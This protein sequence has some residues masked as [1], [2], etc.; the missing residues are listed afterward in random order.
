MKILISGGGLAGLT[1]A[2]WLDKY[3]FTPVVIEQSNGLRRDGYGIDFFGSGY[4]VAERMGLIE[5]LQARPIKAEYV[6]YVNED[7]N[8]IAKLDIALMR[9]IMDGRYLPLMHRT[10]EETLYQAIADKVEVRFGCSLTAITQTPDT[11]TATFDD[12][13]REAFDLLI[14]ADGIHSRTRSL[15][16]GPESEFAHYLGY[17]V[18]CYSLPDH[19]HIGR[20]WQNYTEPGRQVGAYCSDRAGELITLFMWEAP[21]EG[22]VPRAERLPRLRTAFDGMG[23][24]TPQLLADAPDESIFMDTVTQIKM[25][26]WHNGRVALV[27]DACGCMTLISGQGASMALGGAYILAEALRQN[28]DYAAAFRVYQNQVRPEIE[29][30]QTKARDF[31]KAFVPGSELG[32]KVQK[33]IMKLLLRDAFKGV[34]RQQFSGDSILRRALKRLPA[35]RGASLGYVVNGKLRDA[36]YRTLSLDVADALAMHD[37]V[38][39]LLQ[40][41]SLQG[42]E[43]Q[44]LWDDAR[45]GRE[46]GGSIQK[47]AVVGDQRW[48]DWLAKSARPFYARQSRHF[49]ENELDTAWAWLRK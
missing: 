30:R 49:P 36:D 44:A 15:V 17:Y 12:G 21:D 4:D 18:A 35:S 16:F 23:W 11:V 3:G 1:L 29:A 27:G 19:Y 13:R 46:Y 7:G 47:L 22:H 28:E 26:Q 5:P 10:L 45:F 25:T 48:S 33:V 37:E 40:I 39:L 20:A 8:L 43:W 24:I 2:Y 38:N 31:A 32:L 34:L 42:I 14:G 41:E 9:K 6:G